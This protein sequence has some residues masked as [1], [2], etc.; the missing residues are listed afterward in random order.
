MNEIRK[1]ICGKN[2]EI[3]QPVQFVP[4]IHFLT[5]ESSKINQVK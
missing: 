4:T 1:I 5:Q 2:V 3:T